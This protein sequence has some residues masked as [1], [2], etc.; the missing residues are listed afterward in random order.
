MEP[1]SGASGA[2]RFVLGAQRTG[3]NGPPVNS[4]AGRSVNTQRP[5]RTSL[6]APDIGAKQ[7][8]KA[9][10]IQVRIATAVSAL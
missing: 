1:T 3:Q 7:V 6:E 4:G 9:K 8:P 10:R 2:P 5:R